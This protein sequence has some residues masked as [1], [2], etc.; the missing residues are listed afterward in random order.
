MDNKNFVVPE[1]DIELSGY[2]NESMAFIDDRVRMLKDALKEYIKSYGIPQK[3]IRFW[4]GNLSVILDDI[5]FLFHC[6][7]VEIFFSFSVPNN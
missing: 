3:G 2:D 1:I 5:L 6:E 4:D 7:V